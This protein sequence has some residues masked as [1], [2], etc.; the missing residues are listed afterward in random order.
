MKKITLLIA[1]AIFSFGLA[2]QAGN[3]LNSRDQQ[4]IQARAANAQAASN[5]NALVLDYTVDQTGTFNPMDISG[6]GINV[7]L[8][9]DSVSGDLPIGFTFNF[10]GNDYTTF[11]ISSNGFITF[12]TDGDNGC[13]TG[14]V[15]PEAGN[16]DNLIAFAWEDLDPGNGGQPAINVVRYAT[17]GTAPNRVLVVE[18]FN[19]DH[20]PSGDNVTVHTQLYEGTNV[21]EIHTTSQPAI[22][23]N[24]TQGIE[25]IDGTDA[26]AVPGRNGVPWTASNDFVAFIPNGPAGPNDDCANATAIG[27][28]DTLSGDTTGASD[29]NGD[30]SP[31]QW[32]SFNNSEGDW[33]VNVFGSGFGDEVSWELRDNTAAVILSGGPY[34]SNYNDTQM[35]STANEPLE[36]YIE[37]MGFFNDNTPSYTISCGGNVIASG[38]LNGGDEATESNLFCGGGVGQPQWVIVSTCDQAAYDTILTIYDSCGGNIVAQNDDG[39]GCGDFTSEVGFLYDGESTYYIAVDG[40]GGASGAYDISVTCLA[41]PP[42]DM[43]V[44]SIDVDEIGFPYTDPA[45]AMPSATTEDGNPAGCAIDGANGVWYNFVSAGN[46]TA[47]AEI[48][49]PAGASFVVFYKAPNEMATETDLEYFFQINNQCAPGTSASI[50]TEA[51]QAYYLFVVNTGGV[52]DITIDGTLLGVN[53]NTLEGFTYYPNPA[54]EVLNLSSVESIDQVVVYNLL[55]QQIINRK[56]DA[57][58]TQLDVSSLATGAYLMQVSVNGQTGTYKI[59]KR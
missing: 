24:H 14:P 50:T 59:I 12:N 26:L 28:G 45:V 5:S 17:E 13:C 34:A 53:D 15:L 42:N 11:R 7:P 19:V 54:D 55:G 31:D 48:V 22:S 40:F 3:T 44:N 2:Q 39:E 20:F 8:T 52:T 30:G 41:A 49:D 57:T 27:C 21:I 32:Y 9:D 47:T 18:F 35:V 25:N 16:A 1:L 56:I 10:I 37:A 36:F 23:G 38:M 4:V 46:G 51:G 6:S 33:T 58:S 29:T 43:I